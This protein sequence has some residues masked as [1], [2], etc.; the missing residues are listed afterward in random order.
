LIVFRPRFAT[1]GMALAAIAVLAA[2]SPVLAACTDPPQPCPIVAKAGLA[3][4]VGG[5]ANAPA[6]IV[7]DGVGALIDNAVTDGTGIDVIRV[8]GHPSIACAMSFKSDAGNPVALADDLNRFKQQARGAVVATRAKE[9]EANPLQALT[10][11][12]SAAGPGGTVALVDSGLQTVAPL[13]FHVP[14]LLDADPD[15]VVKQLSSIGYLPDL[16]GRTV[17]L[18]GIGYTAPPQ[19]PLDDRRRANL[20]HIWEKIVSAAGATVQTITSPNTAAAPE[21]VPVVSVVDVPP[22]DVIRIGCNTESIL[23]NDGAVGFLPDSATFVDSG[24]A[25]QT[26]AEFAAFLKQNRSAQAGLVGT[27]AHYGTDDGDA[28]LSR[29]RA[30]RVR[31]VL[32]ELGA[33]GNQVVAHGAGWG[34]YP[35]KTGPPS[36]TDDPRNRRVV[37]TIMCT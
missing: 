25:R 19:S 10:L 6:P 35:T 14:G 9:P 26:L 20:V 13:D 23:S 30:Q 5:R 21:N 24:L 22:T 36:P 16:R 28:G 17:V 37:V 32:I 33:D 2:V 15:G 34:P 27:V 3:V 8:D 18:A 7:P 31:D 4:A 1:L 12:A 29:L 11:A